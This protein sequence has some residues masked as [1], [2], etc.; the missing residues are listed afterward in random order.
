MN[1]NNIAI[2]SVRNKIS[3]EKRI[4]PIRSR[5]PVGD[6]M[7][8]QNCVP[9]SAKFV[10]PSL[11][12]IVAALITVFFLCGSVACNNRDEVFEKEQ[13]KHVFA[14]VSG[15]DNVSTHVHDLR[16]AES[17][18]YVSVSL[19]GSRPSA[20]EVRV[21]LVEDARL[22]E[23]YN[24][25]AFDENLTRYI[26]PLHKSRYDIDDD[27]I[28]VPAGEPKASIPIRIRPEGLSPDSSYF[29]ALKVDTYSTY[30]VNPEKD[31]VLYQV[32]I[33]N[34]W[35][36]YGGTTYNQL[37]YRKESVSGDS[38]QIFGAKKLYPLTPASVR[39]MAGIELN[40]N[41]D[42]EIFKKYSMI[43][44]IGNDNQVVIEP[45]RNLEITQIDG[46]PDY[47]NIVVLEDDGFKTYKTFL[48]SYRY[49]ASDDKI[50]TVKEEVRLEYK[51]DPKDPRFLN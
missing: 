43:L 16:Q 14:L 42:V 30:E 29:V 28:V 36:T 13:Y 11:N 50:W 20:K 1:M 21:T 22:I 23:R 2:C 7:L 51:E 15:T 35:A 41:N 17:E 37:G 33:K 34:W 12:I 46:D 4:F 31:Y 6:G 10:M 49:R 45:Y 47:P 48:L 26:Q 5:R 8:G 44:T 32:R 40:D 38:V 25:T 27:E 19:G 39:T 3:V 24:Y 18:G 9:C